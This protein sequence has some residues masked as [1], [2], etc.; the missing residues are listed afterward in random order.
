MPLICLILGIVPI[1]SS[2]HATDIVQP[3]GGGDVV[4][5]PAK[6]ELR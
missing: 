5:V 4:T 6:G 1:T 3:Q 2:K